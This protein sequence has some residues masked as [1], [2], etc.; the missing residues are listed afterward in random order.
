[1]RAGLGTPETLPSL[2]VSRAG[3]EPRSAN[4]P[5]TAQANPA[6]AGLGFR[7]SRSVRNNAL[8]KLTVRQLSPFKKCVVSRTAVVATLWRALAIRLAKSVRRPRRRTSTS[9]VESLGG[10][11]FRPTHLRLLAL[12]VAGLSPPRHSRQRALAAGYRH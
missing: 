11:G 9:S 3:F 6:R 12:A 1:V 10:V 2:L 4:R 7:T 5:R 8:A